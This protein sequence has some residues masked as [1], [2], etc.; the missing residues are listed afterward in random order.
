[1]MPRTF[2]SISRSAATAIGLWLLATGAVEAAACLKIA[3]MAPSGS[4]YHRVLQEIGEAYQ[5]LA[6][7]RSPARRNT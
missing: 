3:S 1:M 7:G 5:E 4:I 2:T 6:R